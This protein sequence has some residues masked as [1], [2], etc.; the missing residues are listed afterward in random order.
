MQSIQTFGPMVYV[1]GVAKILKDKAGNAVF[2]TNKNGVADSGDS[3][4]L[5]R[6]QMEGCPGQTCTSYEMLKAAVGPGRVATSEMVAKGIQREQWAGTA[7]E[8]T[9]VIPQHSLDTQDAK[10]VSTVF[11]FDQAQPY[12]EFIFRSK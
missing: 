5:T 8:V 3:Y 2:D 7:V 1:G 10:H 6:N 12:A 11:R 4:V 9:D